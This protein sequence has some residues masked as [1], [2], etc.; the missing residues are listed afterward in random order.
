MRHLWVLVLLALSLGGPAQAHL[1]SD[2][3]LRIEI[4]GDGRIS[5]Q[6]DIALRD[7]DVAVGL[8][9]DQDGT[10][11]WGELRA[12]Q[13]A[14]ENYAFSRLTIARGA[15]ACRLLPTTL[16]VD[17]HAGSTYAVLPFG[18]EC[19]AEGE[20]SLRYRLLFDLDPSHRGLLTIDDRGVTTAEVLTPEHAE[21][22]LGRGPQGFVYRAL[23]FLELG[24]DHILLGYDHLL[25]VSVLLVTAVFD[26]A[27]STH[28]VPI[29][30]LGRV[31]GETAKTLTAFTL[32]HATVLIPA[33][34][35]VINVPARLVEPAVALTIILA[36]LDNLRS[37][38]P[39][40]RWQVAFFFGLVHGLSFASALGPMRLHPAD[41]ALALACFNLGVEG[42]QLAL[43]ALVIP[44]AFALRKEF[45]YRV[46]VV[47]VISL[48]A[49]ALA[50]V[51]L[52]DRVFGLDILSLQP[53]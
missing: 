49:A 29:D 35:G 16:M 8:D 45:A 38:L 30:N 47:P 19:P 11:T 41:L 34:L 44:T 9:A 13:Q 22:A 2:S 18:A 28:L 42:G 23:Q 39:R 1:A 32:A 6:W 24:F 52:I 21:V 33:V 15:Q 50:G 43:A 37:I 20:F 31:V 36:G 25:F 7:L 40:L 10:I 51:W 4:A 26:R 14:V 48:G 5:G 27:G 3:Y 46:L 53:R 17:R 12:Q